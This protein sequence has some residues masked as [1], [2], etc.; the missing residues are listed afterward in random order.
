[1][2]EQDRR[3]SI[4]RRRKCGD[5]GCDHLLGS[6]GK[7]LSEPLLAAWVLHD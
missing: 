6:L 5:Y 7:W 3:R 2:P 1:M 4:D